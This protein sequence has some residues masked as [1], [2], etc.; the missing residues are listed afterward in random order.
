MPKHANIAKDLPLGWIPFSIW[1]EMYHVNRKTAEAWVRKELI[2]VKRWGRY[3]VIEAIVR[4]PEPQ[5]PGYKIEQVLTR[6]EILKS[7]LPAGS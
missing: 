6:A 7:V 2:P 3:L 4:P 5:L 1:Q